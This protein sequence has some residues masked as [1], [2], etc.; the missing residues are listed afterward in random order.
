MHALSDA[1][2][3]D[4][5]LEANKLPEAWIQDNNILARVAGNENIVGNW[6]F[7][8]G[9]LVIPTGSAF[10]TA[11]TEGGLFWRADTDTL[12]AA[13][14][15]AWQAIAKKGGILSVSPGLALNNTGTTQSPI[16]NVGVD[17]S[18]IV[19]DGAVAGVGGSLKS[20]DYSRVT[21]R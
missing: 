12:Y 5:T 9:S 10:P 15:A 14:G 17:N 19:V 16:L 3:H 13:D 11:T 7:A 18:T 6:S 2:H 4:A 8:A 20:W 1:T 21:D